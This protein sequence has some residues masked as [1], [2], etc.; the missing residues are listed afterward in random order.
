MSEHLP[1]CPRDCDELDQAIC[2]LTDPV[3]AAIESCPG[4]IAVL[5]AGGKMGFHFCRLLQNALDALG[6]KDPVIAVSRFG[7]SH[8]RQQFEA[9]GFEVISA[10]MTDSEQVAKLPQ[11]ENVFFLAGIKFGTGHQPELLQLYNVDM[12]ALVASHY[13]SSRIVALSTGC[14]YAF[15]TPESGGSTEDSPTDPPGAYAK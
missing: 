11:A 5:G 12:P 1:R 13:R 6:R 14:V 7:N 3:V 9:Q 15:T 8:T 2:R 10:D 4:R